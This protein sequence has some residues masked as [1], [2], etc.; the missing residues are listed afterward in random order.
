[1][2]RDR[3]GAIVDST[4][5]SALLWL[6][7]AMAR[8]GAAAETAWAPAPGSHPGHVARA[9]R[10]AADLPLGE[11]TELVTSAGALV[12]SAHESARVLAVLTDRLA[13]API[14]E[15]MA[16]RPDIGTWSTP[17]TREQWW[18]TDGRWW[19]P[20]RLGQ[21]MGRTAGW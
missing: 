2:G 13:R 21:D 15:A 3:A 18:W 7:E 12:G 16:S 20:G 1:M 10:R 19:L 11:L 8:T 4:I 14:A 9:A 17:A 6:L 5:G